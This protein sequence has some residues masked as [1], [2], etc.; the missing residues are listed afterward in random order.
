MPQPSPDDGRRRDV[1]EPLS[2]D[3]RRLHVT[4]SRRCLAKLEEARSALSHSHPGASA[5]EVLPRR[6]AMTAQ[7]VEEDHQEEV[8]AA[9]TSE[10]PGRKPLR[11]GPPILP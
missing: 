9:R 6:E 8:G 10:G 1:A 11:P 5:E 3:L 2:A 7:G 4:V